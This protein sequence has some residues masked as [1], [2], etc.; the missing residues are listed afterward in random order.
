MVFVLLSQISPHLLFTD[1]PAVAGIGPERLTPWVDGFKNYR[2]A[3][4]STA[5]TTT[6]TPATLSAQLVHEHY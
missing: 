3:A 1:V 4:G 5:I 6:T 2:E